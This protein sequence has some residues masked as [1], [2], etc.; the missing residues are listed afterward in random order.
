MTNF[1]R[2]KQVYNNMLEKSEDNLYTGSMTEAMGVY[3]P[4]YSTTF[5]ALREMGCIEVVHNGR[6]GGN[7]S[8]VLLNHAPDLE[9][10]TEMY[11]SPLTKRETRDKLT[12]RISNLERRM[13]DINIT[14]WILSTEQRLEVLEAALREVTSFGTE[15]QA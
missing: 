4:H 10:F 11:K 3:L 15:T 14:D 1:E 7:P 9:K 8:R 12:Q 6:G 2:I 13:P 5:K